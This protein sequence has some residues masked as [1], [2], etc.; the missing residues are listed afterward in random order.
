MNIAEQ[1]KQMMENRGISRSKLGREIGVHTS[2][3]SNWLDG[4]DVKLENLA[5]LCSYFDC[6]MDYFVGDEAMESVSPEQSTRGM[7]PE[8]R[9]AHYR[10][11]HLSEQKEKPIGQEADG[12]TEEELLRISA[13]MAQMNK[14][15]RERAVEMVEDLA[16]GGRFKKPDTDRMGKEA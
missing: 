4:K 13:A 10:G 16:A 5:T 14:E 12:L 3:V 7:T 8:E 1:L 2:T 11:L 15:G 6:S 9:E